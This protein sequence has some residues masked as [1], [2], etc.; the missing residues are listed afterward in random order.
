VTLETL[1]GNNGFT[2]SNS[3]KSEFI[4]Q[5]YKFRASN[6][7]TDGGKPRN[8]PNPGVDP[9]GGIGKTVLDNTYSDYRN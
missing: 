7:C 6:D 2:A 9:D 4:D 1:I 3:F 8:R 5:Y